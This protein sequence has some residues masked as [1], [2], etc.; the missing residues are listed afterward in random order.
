MVN[1]RKLGK[2][3]KKKSP[4]SKKIGQKYRKN[5]KNMPGKS[6]NKHIR[7]N[8][9]PDMFKKLNEVRKSE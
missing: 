9:I 2:A 1:D 3:D 4:P 6:P 8:R 7:M 5:A